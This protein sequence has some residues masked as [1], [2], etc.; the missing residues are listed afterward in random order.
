MR[1]ST[2]RWCR[3]TAPFSALGDPST[4][5]A[6]VVEQI[7]DKDFAIAKDAGFQYNPVDGPPIEVT[8]ATLAKTDFASIPRFMS[9]LVSR[10]GRHTPA[11]LVHDR[12]VVDGMPFEERQRADR[13]FVDMLDSLQVPPVLSRVMWSAVSLATRLKGPVLAKAGIVAWAVTAAAGIA[14]LATGLAAVTPWMIALSFVLP[15]VGSLLWGRQFTAGV[16]AGYALPVVA[17]P[18]VSA[19][20]GYWLYWV[21]ETAARLV[22]QQFRHNADRELTT[23]IGYQGR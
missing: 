17:V 20:V 14:M 15:L 2:W 13:C 18:A 9:W 8:R 5:A 7:T 16:V 4:P 22:R 19:L 23:P 10:H 11:A 6:F 21:I 12:L 3:E 1:K